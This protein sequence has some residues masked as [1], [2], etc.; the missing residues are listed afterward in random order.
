M[1]SKLAYIVVSAVEI[2]ANRPQL[3]RIGMLLVENEFNENKYFQHIQRCA[4]LYCP[5][6]GLD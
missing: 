4:P 1:S 3:T 2:T 6:D 5:D